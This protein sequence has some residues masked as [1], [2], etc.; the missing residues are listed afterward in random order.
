MSKLFLIVS[1]GFISIS[2]T[3][4]FVGSPLF[5][6]LCL[7]ACK[8]KRNL[9]R[10]AA[11]FYFSIFFLLSFAP[12]PGSSMFLGYFT[13]K[14]YTQD[15]ALSIVSGSRYELNITSN[16]EVALKSGVLNN[17]TNIYDNH[18]FGNGIKKSMAFDN[19]L[20]E[21]FSYAGIFGLLSFFYLIFLIF[22]I[23]WRL[24]LVDK[25]MSIYIFAICIL[26]VVANLGSPVFT[27]NRVSIPIWIMFF[28]IS[29][30]LDKLNS[31]IK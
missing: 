26:M 11:I 29:T 13:L 15:T 2:K 25:K 1:G 14:N 3:F 30:Y 8:L 9:L 31:E 6:M 27:L 24:H 21:F 17:F 23:T 4:L 22:Y 5:F 10:F 20:L 12:W 16:N 28:T 18:F 7:L 19:G